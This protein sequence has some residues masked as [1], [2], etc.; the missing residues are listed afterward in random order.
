MSTATGAIVSEQTEIGGTR[1]SRRGDLEMS[2]WRRKNR[3]GW[4][5]RLFSGEI[6]DPM[7]E[8]K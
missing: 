8:F 1:E 4:L 5:S 2:R 7:E 3:N 6:Y